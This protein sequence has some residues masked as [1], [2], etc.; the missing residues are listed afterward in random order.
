M[1]GAGYRPEESAY[2]VREKCGLVAN[3]CGLGKGLPDIAARFRLELV[4]CVESL[5]KEPFNLRQ[6]IGTIACLID[7]RA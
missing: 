6:D 2:R 7:A 4:I 3:Q 5:H 1:A